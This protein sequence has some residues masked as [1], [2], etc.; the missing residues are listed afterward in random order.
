MER[1]QKDLD[2]EESKKAMATIRRFLQEEDD[3][4]IGRLL[5]LLGCEILN[6]DIESLEKSL[7]DSAVLFDES[8]KKG[9]SEA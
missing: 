9:K 4:E 5:R 2:P 1:T 6:C 8:D 3:E 7:Q